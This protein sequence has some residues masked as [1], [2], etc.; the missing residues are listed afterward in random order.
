[1]NFS[2]L[3]KTSLEGGW[4]WHWWREISGLQVCDKS[5]TPF[6]QIAF[7]GSISSFPIA[8]HLG[9]VGKSGC[10]FFW[11]RWET[12]TFCHVGPLGNSHSSPTPNHHRTPNPS[13]LS[14]LSAIFELVWETTTVSPETPYF[15][16]RNLSL[17]SLGARHQSGRLNVVLGIEVYSSSG[18][19][20]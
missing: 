20:L 5:L 1:M 18:G 16:S 15:V 17:I 4:V 3:R 9:K 2:H 12:Q 13:L 6:L 7:K 19:W 14:A 11:H 8:P 10:C